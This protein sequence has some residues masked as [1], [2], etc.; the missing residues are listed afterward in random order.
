MP[1]DNLPGVRITAEK[2]QLLAAYGGDHWLMAP[3][4]VAAVAEAVH[5]I[6][7]VRGV[8]GAVSTADGAPLENSVAA[9]VRDG[10]AIIPIQGPLF[11]YENFA[12]WWYGWSSYD[13]IARDVRAAV[14]NP[15]VRKIVYAVDSPGGVVSGCAETARIIRWAAEQK[16]S[17]AYGDGTMCSAAY[18]LSAAANRVS[19]AHTAI[20]GSIGVIAAFYDF[21]K[22]F[23]ELGIEEIIIVSSQSPKKYSDPKTEEGRAEIQA[24][25]D[26]LAD[27]FVDNVAEYRGVSRDT[28]L[29]EFGQGGVFVGADAVDAA[30]AD[31]LGAFEPLLAELAA[32]SGGESGHPATAPGGRATTTEGS[33]MTL[34]NS[35]SAGAAAPNGRRG[36]KPAATDDA[37]APKAEDEEP[38]DEEEEEG[39]EGD[40][41]PDEEEEEDE[42]P[43]GEE[44]EEEEEASSRAIATA[45]REERD[46]V[47]GILALAERGEEKLALECVKDPKCT[48]ADAALRLRTASKKAAGS[49]IAA[50]RQDEAGNPPPR[51]GARKEEQGESVDELSEFIANGGRTS[52]AAKPTTR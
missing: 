51:A 45:K 12:S 46:R 33:E 22:Y 39:A 50:L 23:A 44:D 24:M 26:A 32:G 3:E 17:V 21:S 14:E 9:T 43:A 8:P 15:N 36:A 13:Q 30:L 4:Q 27:V 2:R 48:V 38:K 10:V 7:T 1:V 37:P 34:R 31:D 52:A 5:Q 16:E 19:I 20:V 28:V 47:L 41:P 11:R 18:W 6:H 42:Q 35:A 29:A 40:P 49:Y 25:L